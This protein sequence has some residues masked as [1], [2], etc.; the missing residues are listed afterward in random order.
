MSDTQATLQMTGE[1]HVDE[2]GEDDKWN[3]G[4]V[5]DAYGGFLVDETKSELATRFEAVSE[6]LPDSVADFQRQPAR[7]EYSAVYH[8]TGESENENGVRV[9]GYSVRIF[10]R[11]PYFHDWGVSIKERHPKYDGYRS[12]IHTD[13]SG[14]DNPQ[15][16]AQVALEFMKS[17][18]A[19]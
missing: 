8:W 9:T 14:L 10:P 13:A 19:Q 5:Y 17:V 18:C 7:T 3:R 2:Y 16:A 15:E 12:Y 11:G 1:R 4:G 6:E